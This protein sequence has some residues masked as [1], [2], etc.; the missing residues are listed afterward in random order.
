MKEIFKTKL[1]IDHEGKWI[2]PATMKESVNSIFSRVGEINYVTMIFEAEKKR[3]TLKQNDYYWS[4]VVPMVTAG[5]ILQG[6]DLKVGRSRDLEM[7]HELLKDKFGTDDMCEFVDM[8]GEIHTA[9]KKTTTILDTKE[10]NSYISAII[11]WSK[12][13]LGINIPEPNGLV[14]MFDEKGD[15]VELSVEDFLLWVEKTKT[16]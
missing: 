5:F 10:F 2:Y 14:F 9:R 7:I 4:V 12:E 1:K 13:Y 16:I 15:Q 6:N 3:R 8:H 11:K